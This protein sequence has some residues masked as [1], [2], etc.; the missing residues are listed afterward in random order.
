MKWNVRLKVA[1]FLFLAPYFFGLFLFWIYPVIHALYLSLFKITGLWEEPKFVGIKN[2]INLFSDERFVKALI[3]TTYYAAASVFIILACALIFALLINAPRIRFKHLFRTSYFLPM[4]TSGV[5]I[6]IMFTLV[7]DHEY[8]VINNYLFAPLGLPKVKWLQTPSFVMPSIILVGLW[9]YTGINT[10]YFLV[11]L[12]NIPT[13]IT[14][15]AIIDGT[16]GWQRFWYITLPLLKP[17]I[18][19]VVVLAIVGSYQLFAEPYLLASGGGPADSGLFMTV[20]L[21]M[22]AFQNVQFGYASAIGYT[23]VII[24]FVISLLQM[25]LMGTFGEE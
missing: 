13:D 23:M 25:K 1:P 17:I 3:N 14:E 8:G 2:Y 18:T 4:L 16:N 7:F 11:G 21:Y 12:Q 10:L 5:V 19:F 24:I 15:A 20:Y 6:A 22:T 9:K